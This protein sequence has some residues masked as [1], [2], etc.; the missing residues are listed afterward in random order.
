MRTLEGFNK[1]TAMW[2]ADRE[3][4]L[5]RLLFETDGQDLVEYALLTACIGFAGAAAWN[6]MQ[7]SLG[8][9]YSSFTKA[10]WDIWEP[11][12]PVG[13]GS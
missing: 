5:T 13:A 2:D 4:Q 1:V 11:A 6:A 9:A 12:D 8:S 10:A 7:T 3:G